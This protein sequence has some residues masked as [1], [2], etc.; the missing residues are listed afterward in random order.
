MASKRL[1]AFFLIIWGW[2]GLNAI[3]VHGAPPGSNASKVSPSLQT[4]SECSRPVK[5]AGAS[6]GSSVISDVGTVILSAPVSGGKNLLAEAR[7][8]LSPNTRIVV[9]YPPTAEIPTNLPENVQALHL[10]THNR[11]VSMRDSLQQGMDALIPQIHGATYGRTK[12]IIG[13]EYGVDWGIALRLAYG[14]EGY[15]GS[16]SPWEMTSKIALTRFIQDARLAELIFPDQFTPDQFETDLKEYALRYPSRRMVAKKNNS[17]GMN[18]ILFGE[19]SQVERMIA[20]LERMENKHGRVSSILVER[21]IDDIPLPEGL[22]WR[23]VA[24]DGAVYT[25]PSD[26]TTSESEDPIRFKPASAFLYEKDPHDKMYIS[27]LLDDPYHPRYLGVRRA[28]TRHVNKVRYGAGGIHFEVHMPADKKTGLPTGHGP[29]IVGD[30]NWRNGGNNF[31]E[32]ALVAR[33]AFSVSPSEM[34]LRSSL[35]PASLHNMA[36]RTKAGGAKIVTLAF[37]M[38]PQYARFAGD[39]SALLK[40]IKDLDT[41]A[42]D[43][44]PWNSQNYSIVQVGYARELRE[45][46]DICLIG[47]PEKILEDE[48]ELRRIERDLAATM[49]AVQRP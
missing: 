41:F 4:Q 23:E 45:A 38:A 26:E 7:R 11:N 20:D 43:N 17:S 19:A 27:D 28:I 6:A 13:A 39:P 18:G 16:L 36:I 12:V 2:V 9:L 10:P 42:A 8:L 29:Y 46:V 30:P 15:S 48:A 3:A 5:D 34:N 21:M 33:G 25:L 14:D 47:P 40:R 32:S 22:F 37:R 35:A 44:I 1:R 49:V 24:F 31:F